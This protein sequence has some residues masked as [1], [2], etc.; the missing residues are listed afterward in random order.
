MKHLNQFFQ[1]IKSSSHKRFSAKFVLRLAVSLLRLLGISTGFLVEKASLC[2]QTIGM[3]TRR[4]LEKG[5]S[6]LEDRPRR[7]R[8]KKLTEKAE[9]RVSKGFFSL[10]ENE[11]AEKVRCAPSFFGTILKKIGV[12]ISR[13]TLY[14][15]LKKNGIKKLSPRPKHYK[16]DEKAS[17]KWIS[18]LKTKVFELKEKYSKKKVQLFFQDESRYGQQ[19]Y[20]S[21]IWALKGTRP[22]FKKQHQFLNTWLYGAVN[23]LTGDKF[24]LVLPHLDAQNMGIFLNEF[25]SKLLRGVHALL[26]LDGSKA[27]KNTILQVPRNI[28]LFFLPPYSPELNPIE[29]L[30]LFIK[31]NFLSL[32]IFDN[33]EKLISEGADAW[34]K[35]ST[36]N[37][38]SICRC[39]YI[40][41]LR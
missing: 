3:L 37:I 25:S 32:K 27:H 2:R 29:R 18:D 9:K 21:K 20:K 14:K 19:T 41:G 16:R 40:E 13:S 10:L 31:K 24:G 1:E 28:T 17:K 22:E 4:F 23:P 8:P 38:K 11:K 30:W 34:N 35:I 12:S 7:G 15:L 5:L 36:E 26:V 39:S 33:I 6:G